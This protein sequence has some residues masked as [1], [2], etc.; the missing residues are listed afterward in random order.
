MTHWPRTTTFFHSSRSRVWQSWKNKG[1]NHGGV[2]AITK[3]SDWRTEPEHVWLS[4][5]EV[6]LGSVTHRFFAT[7]WVKMGLKKMHQKIKNIITPHRVAC[8]SIFLTQSRLPDFATWRVFR[9]ALGARN[10]MR[11]VKALLAVWTQDITF[12]DKNVTIADRI[13][14]WTG[15]IKNRY[16]KR[17]MSMLSSV[18]KNGP[19]HPQ[20]LFEDLDGCSIGSSMES[21]WRNLKSCSCFIC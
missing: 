8:L 15:G 3:T 17:V 1:K 21:M 19:P 10:D 20:R 11:Y 14:C 7:F 2:V 6:V 5:S 12:S 9:R 18:K 16:M 13:L 4:F